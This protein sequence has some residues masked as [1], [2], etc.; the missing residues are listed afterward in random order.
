M[1]ELVLRIACENTSWGY[2]RIVG[3]LRKL[4]IGVSATLVGNI[5]R[6]AGV[7][8]APERDQQDWRSFLRQ[9][10]ETILACDFLTVDKFSR[11]FDE[12]FRSEGVEIIRT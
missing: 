1:R 7:P 4:G 12:V 5:L 9:H 11:A 8:P 2:V 3:E 6:A 10:D